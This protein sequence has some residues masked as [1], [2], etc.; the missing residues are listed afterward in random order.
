M[1]KGWSFF[2]VNILIIATLSGQ[3]TSVN[4]TIDDRLLRSEEKQDIINLSNDV[5]HFFQNTTWNDTYSDI[6]IDLYVQIIFAARICII[7]KLRLF[8]C[9]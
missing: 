5:K 9:S 7:S 4:V 2:F 8:K 1:V 6:K 3:F